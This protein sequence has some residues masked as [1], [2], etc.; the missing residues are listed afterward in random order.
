VT[1][2]PP[3][4]DTFQRAA[5]CLQGLFELCISMPAREKEGLK[6]RGGEVHALLQHP[7]EISGIPGSVTRQ[8]SLVIDDLLPR[9]KQSSHRTNPGLVVLDTGFFKILTRSLFQRLP[10]CLESIV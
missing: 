8:G 5:L 4:S 9:K 6:L 10:V 7:V 3:G 2:S 1:G